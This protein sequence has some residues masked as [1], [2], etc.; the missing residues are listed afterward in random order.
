MSNILQKIE[1]FFLDECFRNIWQIVL[2]LVFEEIHWKTLCDTFNCFSKL[3]FQ[4]VQNTMQN[5][6]TKAP[7]NSLKESILKTFHYFFCTQILKRPRNLL[8]QFFLIYLSQ[9]FWCVCSVAFLFFSFC[10]LR[11]P[12]PRGLELKP[13]TLYTASLCVCNAY[14]YGKRAL[15]SICPIRRHLAHERVKDVRDK[16]EGNM[17]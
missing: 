11:G 9:K 5:I 8:W 15:F 1:S 4:K 7:R 12:R 13:Q 2:S 3:T 10:A 6:F 17:E 16:R 14:V